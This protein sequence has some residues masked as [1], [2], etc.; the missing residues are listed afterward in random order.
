MKTILNKKIDKYFN[1]MVRD[2]QDFI[3][4]KSVLDEESSNNQCPFGKE[5]DRA[6]KFALKKGKDFGLKTK[7][8]DGYAGYVEIG[9]GEDMVGILSHIDVVPAGSGWSVD[10]YSAEIIEDR[11]YGRGSID[12]KGPTIAVLYALHAIQEAQLPT[13]KR[14]RLIVGT[15]EETEGRCIKYYL[16]NEETPLYGFSPDANFPIIYAEKGILRFEITGNFDKASPNGAKLKRLQGGTRVNV[17][18]DY[19]EAVLE[20]IDIIKLQYKIDEL[21]LSEN[22]KVEES[23]KGIIVKAQGISCHAMNPSEGINAIQLLIRLL[24]NIKFTSNKLKQFFEFINDRFNDISG[25]KAGLACKDKVSGNLTINIGVIDL[26]KKQGSV[27]FDVRYP[28]TADGN[29]IIEKLEKLAKKA[30]LSFKVN[31]HKPP[32]Y[33]DKDAEFIK[34]L[35]KVYREMTGQEPKLISIGGGTY[36]RYVENT[37][38]FGPVF[39]GQ[40]ELAHQADEYIRLEDFKLIAK[41][42]AQAIYELIK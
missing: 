5:I 4:I 34:K 23:P 3:K 24:A 42:Y 25:K 7:N 37:V 22:L 20:D 17:V 32:L 39:P 36:C 41:I 15:D 40:K 27:K 26:N 18:P 21:D 8:V 2:L 28:V 29:T 12:D 35:Q 1:N 9:K 11:L 38:S 31:Q 14:A 10:P 6:L 30:K 19:A 33:V 16:Q 13:S